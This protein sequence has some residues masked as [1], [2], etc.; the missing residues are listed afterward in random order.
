[1]KFK[2]KKDIPARLYSG[3]PFSYRTF[4]KQIII[5]EFSEYISDFDYEEKKINEYVWQCGNDY[6]K[7]E[8][9]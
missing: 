1:M 9:I 6:L 7:K 8:E 5:P 2:K 4:V 3:L